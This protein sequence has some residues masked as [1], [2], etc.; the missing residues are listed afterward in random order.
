MFTGVA[1]LGGGF[2]A[3]SFATRI[4]HLYLCQGCLVGLGVGFLYIP[5]I[6]IL[7]QWFSRRRSLANGISAAGSGIGGLMFSLS[8]GAM[9][10]TISLAWSL[11]IIGILTIATNFTAT[12]LIRDR[13]H[14]I[15]PVQASFDTK[16]LRRYDVLLLLLW[17]FV[18]ML[19][20]I[21]LIYS[22]SDFALSIGLSRSQATQVTAYL[23]L[24]TAVGRPFT[25]YISDLLGR[26]EVAAGLTFACGLFIFVIW[27]PST[28]FGL[29][30]FF[31][32]VSGAIL[33][34]FWAVSLS[35][36]LS[37]IAFSSSLDY[38]PVKRRGGRTEASAISSYPELAFG[39]AS[40][41]LYVRYSIAQLPHSSHLVSEVIAL[42]LRRPDHTRVYL[43]PQI[44]CGVCYICA[45]LCLL[46][47][48]R[49]VKHK[50]R[51]N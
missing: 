25:G 17:G 16:L 24:G 39:R 36:F 23:N 20:Y 11:R 31:A 28:S 27:L 34:V 49:R 37:R 29:T 30:V 21:T 43:Y 38:W 46:E 44:F 47:V 14:I 26:F 4:W 7:S 35:L 5:C 19:G 10:R 3:A 22:L 6:A 1:L 42:E 45:S 48:R 8:T 18:S 50:W 2:V 12:A 15:N 33:G 9:I 41:R 13:N 40:N 51:D 32:I